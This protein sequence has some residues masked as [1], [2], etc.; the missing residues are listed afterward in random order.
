MNRDV[1]SARTG[2][3]VEDC[4]DPVDAALQST[5]KVW[6]DEVEHKCSLEPTEVGIATSPVLSTLNAGLSHLFK[7][8][9]RLGVSVSGDNS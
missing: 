6:S 9:R 3:L 8:N 7:L 5:G 4:E 2:E 1:H